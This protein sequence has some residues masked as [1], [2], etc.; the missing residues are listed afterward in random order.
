MGADVDKDG[1]EDC[2][3]SD[4]TSPLVT[5][6]KTPIDDNGYNGGTVTASTP[7]SGDDPSEIFPDNSGGDG[8]PD[9]RDV[10]INCGTQKVYYAITEASPSTITDYEFNGTSHI[11]QSNTKIIRAT[12]FCEPNGDGWNYFYNPLEP[13]NYLF[14]IKYNN[15]PAPVIPMHELVDYIEIKIEGD[16]SNRHVIGGTASNLIMERDWTVEFK[17][18]PTS[19]STFDVKF[20]FRPEEMNALKL[21]A[22]EIESRV[23]G[24]FTRDFY[25]FKKANGLDNSDIST[26]EIEGMTDITLDDP[27]DITDTNTGLTD[28]N[29][30]STGNGKNYVTFQGLSS[31]SGGTAG[32]KLTY[33]VLPVDLVRFVGQSK[34]CK[35]VLDWITASEE[36][37]SHY[38]IQRS[39]DGLSFEQVARING[40]GGS[41]SYAYRFTD[42]EAFDENYY[43]LKMVDLDGSFKFSDIE[44]VTLD[45][46]E[47]SIKLYPNPV[48]DQENIIIEFDD[49]DEQVQIAIY[50]KSGKLVKNFYYNPVNGRKTSINVAELTVGAYLI[51][52]QYAGKREAIKFVKVE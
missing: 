42:E 23:I 11:D 22:D 21:A 2:F 5:S 30:S 29:S 4:T 31:F 19:G 35:V 13:E 40:Q 52:F 39:S 7:T 34:D 46:N 28:G 45:C 18:T 9:W 14:A 37:F 49:I 12:V 48:K 3:D 17:S 16:D 1:L 27:N 8:Q 26:T 32:I 36:N 25:W 44:I 10:L 33:A 43:R 20:Y 41:L 24:G 51:N 6:Y 50:D 15:A 47:S 38:E